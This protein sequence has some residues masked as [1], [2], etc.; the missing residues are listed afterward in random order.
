MIRT[1]YI[2]GQ[3][4]WGAGAICNIYYVSHFTTAYLNDQVQAHGFERLSYA[5]VGI[6]NAG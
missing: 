5:A 1:N 2:A 4:F 3:L 6:L